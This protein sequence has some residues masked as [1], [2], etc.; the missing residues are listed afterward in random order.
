MA[1]EDGGDCDKNFVVS[2]WMNFSFDGSHSCVPDYPNI[3][4]VDEMHNPL[5][6]NI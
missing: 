3:P 5:S 6:P 1:E 2:L 4:S